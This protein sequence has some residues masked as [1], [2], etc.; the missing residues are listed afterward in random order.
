M[1]YLLVV[2]AALMISA[3]AFADDIVTMPTANQLKAGEVDMA[4]YYLGLDAPA[5]N[6]QFVQYQTVYVGLTDK[7]ELD[8][9]RSAVDNDET[10]TVLVGSYKLL[11]ETQAKPDLVV[12]CRNIGGTATTL[13]PA[14]RGKSEDRSYF[15]SAAKTFFLNPMAPGAP[16]VRVHMSLGTADWTLLGEKRHQGIFGGLQFLFRPDLGAVIENDGCDTITGLTYMPKNTGLTIKGGGFGSN[17]WAGVAYRKGL[18][19]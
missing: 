2:A 6:P 19:F 4:A 14:F 13:N 12:G 9:H 1:R 5:A 18:S 17:W 15:V 10:A 16:L 11:S 8:A 7:I 3:C